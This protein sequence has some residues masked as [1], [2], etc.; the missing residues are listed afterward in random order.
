MQQRRFGNVVLIEGKGR[1]RYP[2]ANTLLID[3]SVRAL[4]DPAA[5]RKLLEAVR[6]DGD[7]DIILNTHYHEDHV[8]YNYLFPE[9]QVYFHEADRRGFESL[10][11]QFEMGIGQFL[12]DK[13]KEE[14]SALYVERF[15]FLGW[16]P[17]RLLKDGDEIEFGETLARVVHLPGHTPGH[18]GLFFPDQRLL[19]CSDVDLTPFGPW[20][21]DKAGS[22]DKTI[23]SIEKVKNFDADWFIPSHEGPLYGMDEIDQRA[24]M[25]L[26]AVFDR[27]ERIYEQ[28]SEPVTLDEL[29]GRWPIYGKPMSPEHMFIVAEKAM[30]EKHLDRFIRQGRAIREGE[31]YVAV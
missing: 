13:L 18:F 9:A 8:T 24:D 7:V 23:E 25:Y 20:Y 12:D 19:F 14:Y 26:K 22:L 21:G 28:M 30:I 6:D 1:G 5:G 2:F 17:A 29:A 11:G 4:L 10:E 3:D 16:E 15:H 31:R 27:E